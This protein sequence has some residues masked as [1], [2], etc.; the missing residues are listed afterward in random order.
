MALQGNIEW[1]FIE[2][3]ETETEDIEVTN[4][5]GS[6]ETITQPKQSERLE[7]FEDVYIY[8][9]SIQMH[10]LTYPNPETGYNE[11]IEAV[12]FHYAGYESREAR[13]YDNEDFLFFA[14]SQI[15]EYDKEQNIWKQ[16]YVALKTMLE[17]NSELEDC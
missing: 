12:F 9:K 2:E 16:C 17:P 14:N 15:I 8:I 6:T 10:T 4:P 3:H 7:S 5:D 13:D 11:K 1:V